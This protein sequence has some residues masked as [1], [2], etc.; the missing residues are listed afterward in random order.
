VWRD[1]VTSTRGVKLRSEPT[2]D[3]S[4]S[5]M[6]GCAGSFL[7]RV[8]RRMARKIAPPEPHAHPAGGPML[9]PQL[10]RE[11]RHIED[12]IAVDRPPPTSHRVVIDVSALTILKVLGVLFGAYVLIQVWPLLTLLLTSI[13]LAAALSPYLALLERWGLSRPLALT[14]VALSLSVGFVALIALITP[15]LVTQTRALIDHSDAYVLNLQT[16][17]AQHGIHQDL[18]RAWHT[19]PKKLGNFDGLL[20]NVVLTIFDSTV[21]L[22]TVL[23]VTIYLLSDQE[24]IKT[25][26]VGMFPSERRAEVLDILAELRRQVGGYVRGQAITSLLAALFSFIVL[27]LAGVP[28]AIALAVF[29]GL[30]DLVPMFGGILGM[31]PSVL[32]ALTISPMKAIIVLLGFI[33]YQ[34]V[35]NHLIV[36]RVYSN[37]MNVSSL[38]AL[39]GLLIGAKL[40][41]MLGMLVALP[42]IASLPVILDFAGV[43]IY[44]DRVHQTASSEATQD[45][46]L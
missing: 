20:M 14:T 9:D 25:F 21:A 11:A 5:W 22:G 13:M 34:N 31:L 2:F 36:P 27:T 38:V 35:E 15:P 10:V 7:A 26:F 17:L 42:I 12:S 24:N 44:T 8:L 40:L 4:G 33:V 3:H 39:I 1:S 16:I 41:G 28:N 18:L 32:I 19:V 45:L 43:H 23:F 29:V 6:V 37:T 46:R 30:A